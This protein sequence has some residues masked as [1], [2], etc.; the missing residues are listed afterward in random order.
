MILNE[1]INMLNIGLVGANGRMGRE[2][3]K[4]LKDSKAYKLQ[5]AVVT[6]IK[7]TD[8]EV[9]NLAAVYTEDLSLLEGVD[10]VIDF[11]S[12]KSI[13]LLL[14]F[15]ITHKLPMVIGT[16]GFDAEQELLIRQASTQIAIVVAPNTSLSVNILYKLVAE[17][18]VKLANFEIE[19]TE[20]HHRNKKDAP[21]GT[22]LKI[23]QTVASARDID[24]KKHAVYNRHDRSLTRSKD[25]IGFS[26]IRGGDIVGN[27]EVQFIGDGEI[28]SIKSQIH[29]RASFARGALLA[30]SFIAKQP[31]GF[32]DMASVLGV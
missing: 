4:Q 3:A 26:V 12:P 2:V 5:C 11:S 8:A 19:I 28:L 13:A 10:V 27:H 15:C 24:F 16:T 25:D 9:K 20:A 1:G 6:D 21:S 32:Y 22:A 7:N 14:P 30:A 18:A 31:P 17:A 23:G 29:N